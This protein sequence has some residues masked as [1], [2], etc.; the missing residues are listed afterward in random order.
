MSHRHLLSCRHAL[1]LQYAL[2]S[3]A[4]G[5]ATPL[6]RSNSSTSTASASPSAS[7]SP[8]PVPQPTPP[9]AVSPA[10]LASAA[11]FVLWA[12]Y[13]SPSVTPATAVVCEAH[14][15]PRVDG[16]SCSADGSSSNSGAANAS[17]GAGASGRAGVALQGSPPLVAPPRGGGVDVDALALPPTPL[18]VELMT[19]HQPVLENGKLGGSLIAELVVDPTA[20]S[21]RRRSDATIVG[22]PLEGDLSTQP[23]LRPYVIE[24]YYT[25]EG[26]VAANV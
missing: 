23:S 6:A 18:D 13:Y 4:T 26:R 19:R 3:S 9:P 11:K 20:H 10:T 14:F 25:G 17:G 16:R 2:S 22:W 7:Q 1:H 5:G 8:T 21:V 24:N 12:C 15:L